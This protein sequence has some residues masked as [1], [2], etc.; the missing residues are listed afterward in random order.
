VWIPAR[1]P[2]GTYARWN[3]SSWVGEVGRDG[4]WFVARILAAAGIFAAEGLYV[5]VILFVLLLVAQDLT[6]SAGGTS[7]ALIVAGLLLGMAVGPALCSA[8]LSLVFRRA[9]WALSLVAAWPLWLGQ[10]SL[11]SGSGADWLGTTLAALVATLVVVSVGGLA[12]YG[13]PGPW[14]LSA[15]GRWWGRSDEWYSSHSLDGSHRWDGKEWRSAASGVTPDVLEVGDPNSVTPNRQGK[16]TRVQVLRRIAGYGWNC[17]RA[18]LS[19]GP[20]WFIVVF[21]I[22]ILLLLLVE[23]A[24]LLTVPLAA[25]GQVVD[26]LFGAEGYEGVLSSHDGLRLQLEGASIGLRC[27]RRVKKRLLPGLRYRVFRTRLL[28]WL[29]NY[30]LLNYSS[31]VSL[32]SSRT[33]QA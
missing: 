25:A 19:W 21:P 32:V 5:A 18:P 4:W 27:G 26:S 7:D 33:T 15:D 3:G 17:V 28:H 11:L 1:S 30:E 22:L 23:V 31:P 8:L 9:W 10:A 12:V 24:A 2:D 16:V 6:T 13:T 14:R 20:W 29:V